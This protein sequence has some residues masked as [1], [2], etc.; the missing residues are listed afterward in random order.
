M[1]RANRRTHE[2]PLGGSSSRRCAQRKARTRAPWQ[3]RKAHRPRRSGRRR[4]RLGVTAIVCVTHSMMSK[5]SSSPTRRRGAGTQGRSWY[6]LCP[7]C[8]AADVG[9]GGVRRG[10]D[11]AVTA[12]HIVALLCA[13][14]I[15]LVWMIYPALIACLAARCRGSRREQPGASDR[16]PA[17]VSVIIATRD[18]V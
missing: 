15:L 17:S 16:P 4:R 2:T 10:G 18:D 7:A 14:G 11:E 13:G 12:V 1:C 9:P 3:P 8:S 6:E 5:D